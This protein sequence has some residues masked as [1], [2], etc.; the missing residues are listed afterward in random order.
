MKNFKISIDKQYQICYNI[1]SQKEHGG[2]S[3]KENKKSLKFS[4]KGIDSRF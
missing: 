4:K 1:Y 3:K 2:Q